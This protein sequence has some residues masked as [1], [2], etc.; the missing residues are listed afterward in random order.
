MQKNIQYY[1]IISTYLAITS[2]LECSMNPVIPKTKKGQRIYYRNLVAK[3]PAYSQF[4][5]PK[6]SKNKHV[7]FS[8]QE[9]NSKHL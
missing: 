8:L 2:L 3:D 4:C 6:K 7:S 5:L 1:C 9:P